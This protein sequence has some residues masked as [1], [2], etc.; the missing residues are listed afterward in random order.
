M[1]AIAQLVLYLAFYKSTQRQIA[2]RKG[3]AETALAEVVVLRGLGAGDPKKMVENGHA[4]GRVS[5]I[6]ET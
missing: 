6:R 1:F 3:K 4:N 5:E 2:E